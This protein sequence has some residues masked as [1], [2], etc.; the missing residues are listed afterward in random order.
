MVR[1]A[2]LRKIHLLL[3]LC[4]MPVAGLLAASESYVQ[5]LTGHLKKGDSLTVIDDKFLNLPLTEWNQLKHLSVDNIISF[6]LRHDT[7]LNYYYKTFTCTLNVTIKYFTSRDQ[8]TPTVIDNID[9]VVKYDTLRGSSYPDVGQYRFKNAF[10]VTVVI[11][12]INS[13]EWKDKLPD[14][15]RLKNQILVERKYPFD[16]HKKGGLHLGAI[17]LSGQDESLVAGGPEMPAVQQPEEGLQ[18]NNG[19]L[20]IDWDA[21]QFGNAEEFDLEYTYVDDQG[22]RGLAIANNYTLS[23]GVLSIPD[24]VEDQWMLHDNTRVTVT[25]S[26]YTINLPYTSGYILIRIRGVS[27]QVGT[28]LRQTGDWSRQDDQSHTAAVVIPAH[29]RTINWQYTGSFAEGGKRKEVISYFDGSMRNRQTVTINNS[30]MTYKDDVVSDP[31][32]TAV[33]Q[34][35]IYDIMGRPAMNILPAPVKKNSLDFYPG[36]NLNSGGQPLSFSDINLDNGDPNSCPIGASSLSTASGASQYYSPGN[37]FLDTRNAANYYFTKYVPDANQ[38]PYS[39]TEYTQDNTGRIRRQGGVGDALQIGTQHETTYLYGKPT[40]TQ[41]ERL[42]GMEAGNSSHYLKN[43]VIDPNGQASVSYI[44]AN[45]KTVATALVGNPPDRLDAIPSSQVGPTSFNE[46]LIKPADFSLN[47]A[48]LSMAASS[49]FLVEVPNVDYTLHYTINPLALVT[50]YAN[51]ANQLCNN[52]YYTVNVQVVNSCGTVVA[53]ANSTPFQGSDYTCQVN[54]QPVTQTLTVHPTTIGEFTVNYSLQLSNDVINNQTDYYV[55]HNTDLKKLQD[56]FNQELQNLD[57]AGCYNTC[58]ACKTLGSTVDD[59]RGKVLGLLGTDAF[60]GIDAGDVTLNQKITDIWTAL[61]ARCNTISCTTSPCEQKLSQLKADVLPGGQYALYDVAGLANGNTTVFLETAINVMVNY[62]TDNAISSIS[63]V[64][65]DGVTRTVGSLNQADFIRAYL[66]HPEW[67]DLFVIHHIEYCSYLWCKDASNTEPA[68]NNEVSYTFDANLRENYKSGSDAVTAGYYN[69]LDPLALLSKDPFFHGQ[70]GSIYLSNM[71]SDLQNLTAILNIAPKD[72]TVSPAAALPTKNINQWIDWMLYCKP[73]SASPIAAEITASWQS[74][75][76]SDNCRSVTMEWQM[77]LNYYLQLKSKYYRIAKVASNAGCLDCFIGGDVL[78]SGNCVPPGTQNDYQVVLDHTGNIYNFYINRKDGTSFSSDYTFSY[79]LVSDFDGS[80]LQGATTV[81]AHAGDQQVLIA[82]FTVIPPNQLGFE[83]HYEVLAISCTP[84]ALGTCANTAAMPADPGSCPDPSSF[85][86]VLGDQTEIPNADDPSFPPDKIQ[87][88]YYNAPSETTRP[89]NVWVTV[90]TYQENP[91]VD[92]EG[93]VIIATSTNTSAPFLVPFPIHQSQLLISYNTEHKDPWTPPSNGGFTTLSIP[94]D[95]YFTLLRTTYNVVSPFLDCPSY[96]PPPPL[97]ASVCTSNPNYAA[98]QGKTRVFTDYT[99]IQDYSSCELAAASTGTQAEQTDQATAATLQSAVSNLSSAQAGWLSY[100]QAVRNEEFSSL[101]SSTLSDAVLTNLVSNLAQVST[102]YLQYASQQKIPLRIVSTLPTGVTAANGYHSFDEVFTALIGTGLIHQGFSA[103]LL[104]DVFPY[105]KLPYTTDPNVTS[106]TSDISGNVSSNLSA[107]QSAWNNTGKFG[108]YL[109][110]QLGDDYW[111][112]DDQLSDLQAKIAGGCTTPYLKDPAI[113]PVSFVVPNPASGSN[114]IVSHIDCSRL[115][116]LNSAFSA[117]Y[118]DVPADTKLYRTLYTNY[119]NHQ[120]GY[121]LSY[122]DYTTFAGK[123]TTDATALLYDKPLNPTLVNDYFSCTADL[124]SGVYTKAGQAYDLYITQVRI[125]FRNSYIS[126]CLSN[127]ASAM[128]S[129]TQYEYHY[130]LYYYDQSGNLVKTIPPEGVHLLTDQEV[131]DVEQLPAQDPASC[132]VFP[133]GVVTDQPTILSDLSA[134]LQD[135]FAKSMEMWLYNGTGDATRQLRM[136]TPDNK[137]IYQVAIA[138]GRIWVEL[139]TMQPDGAGGVTLTLNNQAIANLPSEMALKAWTHLVVQSADG[140]SG[141]SLQVYIDNNKLT[142]L[143]EATAPYPFA[144][145]INTTTG[146][147]A[148]P[149]ADLSSIRH[150]RLYNRPATDAEIAAEY[151]NSCLGPLGD[152]AGSPLELWGR[153]GIPSYCSEG[154]GSVTGVQIPNRG[155]LTVT[156]NPDPSGTTL[157]NYAFQGVT[158]TFTMEFWVNP[159]SPDIFYS[160]EA[161]DIFAGTLAHPYAISPFWGG[162]AST[163]M[164]GVGVSVGTNGVTVFEHADQ[165]VPAVLIWQGGI[166]GWTHIAIVYNNKT[167]SLYINGVYKTTGSTS[168]KNF[169]VPSYNIGGGGYGYL[170]GSI[171]EVRIWN[172]ARTADQLAANYL[173]TLPA[174]EQAGLMGYWPLDGSNGNVI[175]DISCNNSNDAFHPESETWATSGAPLTETNFVEYA[176]RFIVPNHGLPTTYQYNSLNQVVQQT[177]PDGGTSTFLYDRLGRMSISQNAEQRQP[178]VVDA[179]NP[180]NRFSY[181]RYDALGRITEVGEKLGAATLTEIDA[182]I[183][184]SLQAWFGSG[185]NRQVTVTAYDLAPTW[186]PANLT[187]DNLRKRVAATALLSTGSDPSQNRLAGSYYNYDID[188]N[189]SDLVQENTALINNEQQYVNGT[190]GLKHIKYEYDLI[191]GKVNKV[192]YQDGKWDQF[193]YQYVYDADNRLITAYSNRRNDGDI[194]LWT[195][196]AGYRYYLHGLLARTELGALHVQG[197][198]YTYT[199]QGWLKGVNGQATTGDPLNFPVADMAGDGYP[200]SPFYFV[201]TDALAYSLGYF[202][203]DYHPIG[204]SGAPAF[205]A[206]YQPPA[207]V[208]TETGKNLYNGNISHATYSILG[209]PKSG[210]TYRY[211]QLNRLTAMDLHSG[212]PFA[213]NSSWDN[214]SIVQD[215]KER[216]SYD[217]NGNIQT[218][219]RNGNTPGSGEALGS[220]P[221]S[222]DNLSYNYN[223]DA[224]GYLINNRLRHVNDLVSANAYPTNSFFKVHYDIDNQPND[225]YT[226]DA[227]GNLI[228]DQT[229]NIQKINW[230][231][232]GKIAS[233]ARDPNKPTPTYDLVSNNLISNKGMTFGYDPGGNRITKTSVTSDG[234]T[235]T[236]HYVRDA[237]GNVLGV[238]Q[239]KVNSSGSP[240]EARWLE[241]DLY[242]TSRLGLITSLMILAP[243][244]KIS[245]AYGGGVIP[246]GRH[247]YELTNHLGNVMAV[248]SDKISPIYNPG[249][250][251][252]PANVIANASLIFFGRNYSPFGM[253]MPGQY[254]YILDGGAPATEYRYGFNGKENDNEVE[255]IGNQ[256]DY[257]ERIYDPRIGRFLSVDPL[258]KK[259]AYLTP[260]QYASN[261]PIDG[262]DLDGK[263]WLSH[264]SKYQYNGSGWDYLKWL[265]NAAGDVW[266]GLVVDTWNSGVSTVKSLGRGTYIKDLGNDFK[267]LGSSLKQTAVNT[268]NYTTQTSLGQQLSD[269]GN[270]LIDP[271]SWETGLAIYIV[272]KIPLP[273][274]GNKGNLL[275]PARSAAATT[276]ETTAAADKIVAQGIN[277]AKFTRA[278]IAKILTPSE[279]DMM[280]LFRGMTGNEGKPGVLFLAT[281]R[282]YA[283]SYSSNVV[284]FQISRSGFKRLLNEGL[285]ETKN[286]INSV[287]GAKGAEVAIPNPAIKEQVLQSAVNP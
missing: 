28:N 9:L 2:V 77:Y 85:H 180:A 93:D 87:P 6:E 185:T 176:G 214:S 254:E 243:A 1:P 45:G 168:V 79:D 160:G 241:Q 120:L 173:K 210:F 66:K 106:L 52:C 263:E 153:L 60:A 97:P 43:M 82:T 4:C 8:Q 73:S 42:F 252:T 199:L 280:S 80:I 131:A 154:D 96:T 109:K 274:G 248:I 193:Y 165:Y 170:N 167:P 208:S 18:I 133:S 76:P 152:L 186:A 125:N 12:S 11:N 123:C 237:Q 50:S 196:E 36:F 151:R 282:E 110:Q 31:D 172:T 266:N 279:G 108:D 270:T 138:N 189:V 265:P 91:T 101:S 86:A 249:L 150:I 227:I 268:W 72:F 264:V 277:G 127:Q 20:T 195:R 147:F 38:Y 126:K 65:D 257:G 183:D 141:G 57:L 272:A 175:K 13:P 239:F 55:Q 62:T 19:H 26:P 102:A 201:G 251:Q 171:D 230:T 285:L 143:P 276:A 84:S 116:A 7:T 192:L 190:D 112:T 104:A 139:Y 259:F 281:T 174:S 89:L 122:S 29:Q 88:L 218:Y 231:V 158:N 226:Y 275:K 121:P 115:S 247:F 217:G 41:L 145:E 67:A 225:N 155:A 37:T 39:L 64:G 260:Y 124:L 224:N 202:G 278:Q 98:Y 83:G 205:S 136:V 148:L 188:G 51:G 287:N 236:L 209:I 200:G 258:F 130:T 111:L 3:L 212:L 30:D 166:S 48:G 25:A 191:S 229:Q 33:V 78:S 94:P 198:D 234:T 221:L 250:P 22:G 103:D 59:F 149:A 71:Q 54:P 128:V 17:H 70:H 203:G 244:N 24:N 61:K 10:K 216:I 142:T 255:G 134:D 246:A 27:Y 117:A 5:A 267:Q 140:L 273:G 256:V 32:P 220:G 182:R 35:T 179:E 74:C 156:S 178:V 219:L 164:A 75:T 211:D 58:D 16:P 163:G 238:Y 283:A 90:T 129:G 223:R 118:P 95:G 269:A 222:M 107:F 197:T 242:G 44:D 146:S 34:E 213:T 194:N 184:A 253:E 135:N 233:I 157:N 177:S 204:G 181:T 40:S 286:G 81:T 245:D 215:L 132:A 119:L 284:E 63:F 232:Y 69:H 14:V 235:V 23:P 21:N 161:T 56:F 114:P 271:K 99:D 207:D 162:L 47:T 100:L 113:L 262:I 144:W 159:Q 46:T 261:R 53:S 68:T 206:I 240:T 228:A 187:Q 92:G 15:F 137:Y 169:V 105:D 49:T